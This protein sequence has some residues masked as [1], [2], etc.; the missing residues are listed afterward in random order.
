LFDHHNSDDITP[1]IE[2]RKQT[3]AATTIMI[4]ELQKKR[5]IITPIQATLFLMGIYE[6]TGNLTFPSTTAEDASATAYL[7]DRKADLGILNTFL[8]HSYGKQQKDILFK[9]LETYKRVHIENHSISISN[10]E[11][12]GRVQNLALVIQMYRDIINVNAAFGI[13]HDIETNKCMI[14]G[15]S[16][17]ESINIG[18][19][20]NA[21]GGGGHPGAGSAQLKDVN[22]ATIE[23]MIIELIK[24]ND[25]GSVNLSDIM[26]YP[27]ITINENT[28]IKELAMLLRDV[29]C[30][31]VPVTDKND[32]LV[33]VISRRDFK[34]IKKDSQMQSP[35]KAFMTRNPVSISYDKSAMEAAKK[36]IKYDI[37]RI[38]IMKDNKIIGIVT[39]SDTMLYF[40]DL[41]PD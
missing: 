39:R 4:Q 22:P 34:K 31:G 21:L 18:N 27:V 17:S 20:M 25:S 23:T 35:V 37:G 13:F 28:K 33:G 5:K 41:L 36:M 3:G 30:T 11:I 2:I 32:N 6:D 14:I 19:I 12:K 10:V 1:D 26:S 9:M 40:Y 15:R 8:Q 38:P 24:G 7:L 16:G 29:G